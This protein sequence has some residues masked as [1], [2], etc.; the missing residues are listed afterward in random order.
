MEYVIA[1]AWYAA[2]LCAVVAVIALVGT[3]VGLRLIGGD[4]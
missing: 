2:A 1:N 4:E 3:W